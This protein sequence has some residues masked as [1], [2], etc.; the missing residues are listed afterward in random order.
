MKRISK[1][2]LCLFAVVL[3][4]GCAEDKLGETEFDPTVY[5]GDK[6]YMTVQVTMPSVPGSR[7]NTVE[8]VA[9]MLVSKSVKIMRTM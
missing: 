1:Y 4:A 7:S 3:T 2:F 8:G 6:A 9:A 5:E